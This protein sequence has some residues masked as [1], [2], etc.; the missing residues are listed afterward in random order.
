MRG[1]TIG[2]LAVI[3]IAVFIAWYYLRDRFATVTVF[4]FQKGLHYRDGKFVRQVDAGRY[5]IDTRRSEIEVFDLRK[6]MINIPGQDI[7][8]S[9]KANVKLSLAGLYEIS[10]PFKAKNA[11]DHYLGRFY[12]DAQLAVRD[13]VAG[14]TVDELLEQRTTL[15]DKL[16]AAMQEKMQALG[17]TLHSLAMRDIILPAN[18]KRA[19]AGVLEAQM[20]AQKQLEKARG[21]QAVLRSLANSSKMY[22]NNPSLLQARIVQ[23]LADGKNTIVY[24]AD[25]KTVTTP[26]STA[27]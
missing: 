17:I 2:F 19:Y 6:S 22:D 4:E 10:D 1:E 23:A 25:G 20:E 24:S 7:L 16:L 27:A 26:G 18:L 3:A 8:T 11:S 14:M 12:T 15:D 21:E 5:W 13:L 9:D